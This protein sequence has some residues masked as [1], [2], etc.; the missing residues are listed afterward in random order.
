MNDSTPQTPSYSMIVSPLANPIPI[1]ASQSP[2]DA[3]KTVQQWRNKWSFTHIWQR[4]RHTVLQYPHGWPRRADFHLW[5]LQWHNRR[6][7]IWDKFR[8]PYWLLSRS[9]RKLA[10]W[11]AQI[12]LM[13]TIIWGFRGW[14]WG[15]ASWQGQTGWQWWSRV[16]LCWWKHF[17]QNPASRYLYY[18]ISLCPLFSSHSLKDLP[19]ARSRWTRNNIIS[20]NSANYPWSSK[21]VRYCQLSHEVRHEWRQRALS[22]CKWLW[23]GLTA[24]WT[25]AM[26]Q[27]VCTSGSLILFYS[28]FALT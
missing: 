12:F 5:S 3:Y 19:V 21:A 16:G 22:L 18:M 25:K 15:G 17:L 4:T 1:P 23:R 14:N 8:R 10:K 13:L 2:C 24:S 26:T 6:V 9:I 28:C 20:P 27:V 11:K 7:H